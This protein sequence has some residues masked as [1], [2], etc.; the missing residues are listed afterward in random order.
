MLRDNF[1]YKLFAVAVAMVIWAYASQSQNPGDWQS[2]NNAT[3]S[4]TI[5]LPLSVRRLEPGCV[6]TSIPT[7][8][9]VR[10]QGRREYID[11]IL[12]EPDLVS[13]Y[14]NLADAGAGR[15]K[16]RV[17]LRTDGYMGLITATPD[18]FEVWVRV[19][20]QVERTFD[21]GMQISGPSPEGYV[22]GT[23]EIL[24]AKVMAKG[25]ERNVNAIW[26]V[27]VPVDPQK[28]G[29]SGADGSFK[30]TAIDRSGRTIPGIQF[31][32]AYVHL[33]LDIESRPER[34]VLFINPNLSG[35]PSF[36]FRVAGVELLPQM[37]TVTG[38]PDALSKIGSVE[39]EPVKLSGRAKSFRQRVQLMLPPGI[40]AVENTPV[41]LSVEIAAPENAEHS[42]QG[43]TAP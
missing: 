28:M 19:E 14:V 33:A 2:F 13:V 22:F 32:P 17:I 24:P 41:L 6:V 34:K 10:I 42:G 35:Q 4:R 23:P 3:I 40:S 29:P 31:N 27:V 9:K 30:V 25:I 20:N 21:V 11:A 12:A 39:T 8:I 37:V 43:N 38:S 36:P 7:R 15:H 1:G 5:T 26:R 16:Q 18:P